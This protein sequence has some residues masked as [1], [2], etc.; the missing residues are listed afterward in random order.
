MIKESDI[1]KHVTE[2]FNDY[3]PDFKFHK[4]EYSLRNFRV[5]ILASF[6][7]DLK[8]LGLRDESYI[9]E[10]ALFIEVKHNSEMRELL[11]ELKKQLDFQK[12]YMNT[13]KAFCMIAVLSDDFDEA[14]VRYMKKKHNLLIGERTAEEIKIQIGTTYPLPEEESMEVRG[15]NLLTGLPKTVTVTSTETEAALQ[16]ATGQIVEAVIAILEQTPPEL[17]ADVLDRGIVLT[18][19]GAML[20]G[21][22]ELIAERTGINTMTAEDPLK[23]VAVGTGQF[24]EFMSNNKG[25]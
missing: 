9:C 1:V 10:P 21:L 3:F 5:D 8:D 18:G 14:I 17:S 4:T 23:A 24:V 22:E 7:T 16:E 20:R 11:F 15:R 2:H 13:A 25:I 6:K 19:G 12:W